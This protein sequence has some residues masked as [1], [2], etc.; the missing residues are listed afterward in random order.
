MD[1]DSSGGE[2][3]GLRR[4]ASVVG[5]F[6]ALGIGIALLVLPGPGLLLVLG[7]LVLLSNEF[8]WARRLTDPVRRRAM[9]ATRASVDSG[10]RI[11]GTVAAGLAL[12]AAGVVWSIVDS[13]PFS[14]WPT[15][16]GLGLSGGILLAVLGYSIRNYRDPADG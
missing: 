4:V 1:A 11:A 5:G 9:D 6:L 7:G 2:H 16:V 3:G 13:L 14:G 10:W 15:G 12:V 8:A